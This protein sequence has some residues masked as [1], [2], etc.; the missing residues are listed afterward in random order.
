MDTCGCSGRSFFLVS[1]P[2][3][4]CTTLVELVSS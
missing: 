4:E 2:G 3:A 1:E